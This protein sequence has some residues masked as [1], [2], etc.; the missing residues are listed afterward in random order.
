VAGLDPVPTPPPGVSRQLL[1]RLDEAILVEEVEESHCRATLKAEE[2]PHRQPS[3]VFETPENATRA[4]K[5]HRVP[6]I[7]NYKSFS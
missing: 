5:C 6:K 4:A 7:V 3:P 1:Q 2:N